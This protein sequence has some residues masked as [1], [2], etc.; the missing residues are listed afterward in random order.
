MSSREKML[1]SVRSALGV[2][3]AEDGGR[4]E[5]VAMRLRDHP[6]NLIP[7]RARRGP[8]ERVQLFMDILKSQAATVLRLPARE[9]PAA[10]AGYLRDHNLPARVRMGG[11]RRLAGLPWGTAKGLDCLSGRAEEDDTASLSHAAAGAS[12]TGTLFLT[13]GPDNPTTLNFLPETH[14]VVVRS[15]DILGSYED[16]WNR[17]RETFGEGV[18]PRTVNMVSGPSRTADIEQTI[19]MGAHGPRRLLV[20]VAD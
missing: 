18:M 3:T 17:L 2:D 5:T 12:E 7:Q 20:L 11:D 15:Q 1:A 16:V 19:V 4:R 10:V 6:S 8:E 14:M 13:S 9:I